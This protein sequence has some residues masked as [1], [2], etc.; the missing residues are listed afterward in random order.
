MKYKIEI[1]RGLGFGFGVLGRIQ[2]DYF[3]NGRNMVS[4]NIHFLPWVLRVFLWS[5][6]GGEK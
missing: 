6:D 2:T 1:S 3:S 4:I 5:S